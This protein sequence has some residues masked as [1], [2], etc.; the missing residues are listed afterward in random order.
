MA[1]DQ[2]GRVEVNEE[3]E[4]DFEVWK[5]KK[6]ALTVPLRVVALRGSFPP[7][8]IKVFYPYSF[9]CPAKFVK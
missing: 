3:L 5:T 8:W 9:A 6:F 2:K 1:I 7:S 4:H